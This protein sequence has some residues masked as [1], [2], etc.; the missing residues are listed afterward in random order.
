MPRHRNIHPNAYRSRD[1]IMA[2]RERRYEQAERD[3]QNFL[4]LH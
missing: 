4:K 1:I 2:R 3:S